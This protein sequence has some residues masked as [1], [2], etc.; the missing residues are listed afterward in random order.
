[1]RAPR[2]S[3][4]ARTQRLIVIL[5][6]DTLSDNR[7]PDRKTFVACALWSIRDGRPALGLSKSR[8]AGIPQEFLPASSI[9]FSNAPAARSSSLRDAYNNPAQ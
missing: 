4:N 6:A 2:P 7:R 5:L 8:G 1:M 3:V 9:A